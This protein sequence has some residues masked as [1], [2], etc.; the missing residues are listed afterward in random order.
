MYKLTRDPL[1]I[2]R[3][4][5]G[6]CIP[7]DPENGDYQE[8]VRWRDGWIETLE[9]T[10]TQIVHEPHTPDEADPPAP[11][12]KDQV[13]AAAARADT[14]VQALAGMSPAEAAQWIDTNVVD[15]AS[16][17]IALRRM[18]KILCVLARRL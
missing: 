16:A 14:N 13:D 12:S 8:F 9:E 4:A 18:A 6:A 10:G 11:P 15:F 5:D 7:V 2:L 1:T 3:L 17:K